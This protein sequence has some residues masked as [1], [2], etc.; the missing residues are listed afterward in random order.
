M[1]Q[2]SVRARYLAA[3]RSYREHAAS[4]SGCV[5]SAPADGGCEGARLYESFTRLQDAYLNLQR[6]QRR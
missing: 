2:P 5:L 4:C 1:P 6:Q 3:D